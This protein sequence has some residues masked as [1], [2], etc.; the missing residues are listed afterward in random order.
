MARSFA[1][2]GYNVRAVCDGEEAL[3][4]APVFR[5]MVILL[6]LLM[7]GLSSVDV[8]KRLKQLVPPPKVILLGTM[9]HADIVK[10]ALSLGADFYLCKPIHL[11]DIER[12]VQ[13]C[14]APST[15]QSV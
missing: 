5:P 2:K 14:V 1:L 3:A 6:N 12:L 15:R 11:P 4:L 7:P 9:N 13:T 8:L 10:G